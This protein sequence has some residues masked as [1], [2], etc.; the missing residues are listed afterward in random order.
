MK[1]TPDA[2]RIV[3][4]WLHAWNMRC[5]PPDAV[6]A[7]SGGPELEAHLDIC[8]LCRQTRADGLPPM[9]IGLEA[10]DLAGRQIPRAGELWS[11]AGALAGWGP[12]CRYYNPPV[13]LVTGLEDDGAVSVVQTF[14]DPVLAGPGDILFENHITGFAEPWNRYTVREGDLELFLGRV[15]EKWLSSVTDGMETPVS[16]VEP[17]SLLWFFRHMEV[18]TGWYFASQAIAGLLNGEDAGVL[19]SLDP[20]SLARDLGRLPLILPDGVADGSM[21]TLLA[22]TMPADDL[23]PHA[24]ADRKQE[25]TW[26]LKF[27]VSR[28]RI[29]DVQV[30]P[31]MV[32]LQ[33]EEDGVMRVSG[34]CDPQQVAT[35]E[36]LFR[37]QSAHW[38]VSPLA[39]QYGVDN[40]VF[41]AAF[42]VDG[43]ADPSQGELVIRVLVTE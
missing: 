11:L 3:S 21:P 30:V 41:W 9:D 23:L 8:P 39:G 5:C 36:W 19:C 32:T 31:A 1:N 6:L 43:L 35:G 13:V 15:S 38:S 12:K 37:W 40:G 28:G 27:I 24:A 26:I 29:R 25:E 14:G 16:A 2:A 18:E 4:A 42:S 7:G 17:G 20:A 33:A 10:A 22:H 34:H